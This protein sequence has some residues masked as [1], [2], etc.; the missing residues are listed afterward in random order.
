M[1]KEN[2]GYGCGN[3]NGGFLAV[4]TSFDTL[5]VLRFYED[6]FS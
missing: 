1:R 6:A 2:D 4:L 3:E 5:D